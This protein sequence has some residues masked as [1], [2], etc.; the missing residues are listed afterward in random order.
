M[1]FLRASMLVNQIEHIHVLGPKLHG[2]EILTFKALT[3][4]FSYYMSNIPWYAL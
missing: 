2:A 1:R 3:W 4:V